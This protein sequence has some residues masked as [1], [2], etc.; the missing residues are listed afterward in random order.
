[1]SSIS[2]SGDRRGRCYVVKWERSGEHGFFL[3]RS[4]NEAW[5]KAAVAQ[6]RRA[7]LQALLAPLGERAVC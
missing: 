6:R 5:M 2:W 7:W 1:M 4:P 3:G